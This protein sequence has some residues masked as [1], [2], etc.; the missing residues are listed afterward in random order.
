MKNLSYILIITTLLIL[1]SCDKIATYITGRDLS[2]TVD[3]NALGAG[4]KFEKTAS[5]STADIKQIIKEKGSS[6][7]RLDNLQAD[8]AKLIIPESTPWTFADVQTAEVFLDGV[9]LGALPSGATGKTVKLTLPPKPLDLKEKFLNSSTSA[10][11][12]KVNIVAKNAIAATKL[13]A[14]ISFNM[15][16]AVLVPGG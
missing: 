11:E 3:V 9:S 2:V 10:F 15:E 14:V 5:L 6:N 7:I 13:T 16:L 12:I 8:S 1:S 4:E